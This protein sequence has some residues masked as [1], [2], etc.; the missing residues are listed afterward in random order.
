MSVCANTQKTRLRVIELTDF[1]V[2]P[3]LK[4]LAV[5]LEVESTRPILDNEMIFLRIQGLFFFLF[6]GTRLT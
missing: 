4:H 1:L 5:S 6:G 2:E 3:R